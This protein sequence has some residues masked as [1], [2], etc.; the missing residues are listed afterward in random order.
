MLMANLRTT[1]AT[2]RMKM[3]QVVMNPPAATPA[4]GMMNFLGKIRARIE[5][6]AVVV[7]DQVPHDN[8]SGRNRTRTKLH[9]HLAHVEAI[10]PRRPTANRSP[11]SR[12]GTAAAEPSLMAAVAGSGDGRRP[13]YR[14]RETRKILPAPGEA[15]RHAQVVGTP[16]DQTAMAAASVTVLV[17]EGKKKRARRATTDARRGPTRI[18]KEKEV[19]KIP[20][21]AA[22]TATTAAT[23]PPQGPVRPVHVA[24]TP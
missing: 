19:E 9:H 22:T 8:R 7:L 1:G 2:D 20:I 10:M 15:S 3:A 17:V 11:A 4:D 21:P 12:G 5:T 14:V 13:H 18:P 23:T 6:A 16:L 24:P